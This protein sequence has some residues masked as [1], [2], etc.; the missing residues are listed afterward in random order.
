[1]TMAVETVDL[2]NLRS[3]LNYDFPDVP[4]A[5][6]DDAIICAAQKLTQRPL[7][8]V[9]IDLTPQLQ[10]GESEFDFGRHLPNDLELSGVSA[11]MFCG[12]CIC[13]IQ[14]KCD[15]CSCGWRLCDR[16]TIQMQPAIASKSDTLEI[17]INLR[18]TS[19]ACTLPKV[20]VDSYWKTIR[21]LARAEVS[22]QPNQE[23][24]DP[25]YAQLMER[26][27]MGDVRSIMSNVSR[28]GK[29]VGKAATAGRKWLLGSTR[30]RRL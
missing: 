7:M 14:D 27:A 8:Q 19:D 26:R 18:P 6:L 10:I 17:C 16:E 9:T 23:H 4:G 21:D 29:Q 28:N 20:L 15:K 22:F 24:S 25:R 2:G 1:M 30:K 11:V 3:K 13:D 12:S 5:A